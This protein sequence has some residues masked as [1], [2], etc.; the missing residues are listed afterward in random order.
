MRASAFTPFS[1]LV[2]SSLAVPSLKHHHHHEHV[3]R[4]VVTEV[5]YVTL[6][7]PVPGYGVPPSYSEAATSSSQA[8]PPPPP[9]SS[10]TPSVSAAGYSAPSSSSPTPASSPTPSSGSSGGKTPY[11]RMVAFGDNLSDNGNG[12]SAHGLAG[13]PETIYGFGTW[14]NGPVAVSYLSDS[15]GLPLTDYAY[16]HS[17]GG[18][19]FGAT[20]D[21]S[22]TK[23]DAGVP[24]AK[25][26]ISNY[27]SQGDTKS[28][29]AQTMHFLWIG[30]NDVLVYKHYWP[31]QD[32]TQNAQQVAQ[33]ITTQVQSLI[34]AG[35]PA[36]FVPNV[37][38]RQ[39]APATT[40]YLLQPGSDVTTYG[41]FISQVNTNL[42]NNLKQFGNKVLL[43][44]VYSFMSAIW[45]N[46]GS[47]GFTH[48][49]QG[50]DWCDGCN[51]QAQPGVSNW[52]LCQGQGQANTFFWMQFL[53]PTT[54]VHQL[55]A[56][57]MAK[58]IQGHSFS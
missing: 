2:A 56:A 45:S 44:D 18:S 40:Q 20:I 15:L 11:T 43:Y 17:D 14:T 3:Q 54:K 48:T 47:Q 30:N 36:V 31:N 27:T 21:N 26:Q 57:D 7:A 29:M 38:P 19:K 13:N 16:G 32:N 9:T 35:A 51:E 22:F 25:D 53:D 39:S 33:Q 58:A 12:S 24:S 10:A 41:R 4:D 55:I 42:A 34:S 1:L 50:K 23:S 8:A 37:Y 52:D 5:E 6:A 46:P 28:K 49:Q